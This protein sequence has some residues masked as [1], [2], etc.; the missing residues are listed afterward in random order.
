MALSTGGVLLTF[1]RS[2]AF[3]TSGA[4]QSLSSSVITRRLGAIFG[5]I[6]ASF[7]ARQLL[8]TSLTMRFICSSFSLCTAKAR[9][10]GD[11]FSAVFVKF[12]VAWR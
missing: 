6:M 10:A 11:I 3:A 2:A 1:V 4:S 12:N 5:L 8:K 7:S 9:T